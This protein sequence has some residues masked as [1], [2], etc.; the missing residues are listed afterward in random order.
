[1]CSSDLYLARSIVSFNRLAERFVGGD[2][3][4]WLETSVGAGAGEMAIAL[5]GLLLSVLLAWFLNRRRIYLRL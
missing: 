3:K 4:K 1:M 2:I 5:T